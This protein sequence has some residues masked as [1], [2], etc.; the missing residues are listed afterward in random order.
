MTHGRFAMR[1]Y[2]ELFFRFLLLLLLAC[3]RGGSGGADLVQETVV[4]TDTTDLPIPAD[5]EEDREPAVDTAPDAPTVPLG[6]ANYLIVTAGNL[7]ETA[8]AFAEYRSQTGHKTAVATIKKLL[9][10]AAAATNT[11]MVTAITGWV[12]MYYE[13]RE[14]DLPFFLL[15]V[16]DAGATGNDPEITV[17]AAHWPGGWQGC[18]S[19]NAYGEMDGDDVPDLAVGRI[20]VRNNEDGLLILDKIIKHETEYEVG[21]WN[22]RI[23]V[24]A[25]EGGFGDDIDLAI[26]TIAQE[27][28]ESVPA[29]YDLK[30]AYNSP[31]SNYY[32]APFD[33]K[34]LDMLTEG[35]LLV[36]FM[37]HG[38]GE[39]NVPGSLADIVPKHRQPMYA[40]FA[41][42]TGDF[43]GQADCESETILK[44]EGGPIALLVSQATTHP[45]ANAIN[46]LEMEG[47]FF[48]DMPDTF[49]EAVQQMKWRSL[50]GD[51][52]IRQLIDA[53]APLYMSE[54]E[55]V[56]TIEDHMYSYNLLGDPATLIRFPH[57]T[58]EV[59]TEDGD[60]GGSIPF[61]GKVDSP[62]QGTAHVSIVCERAALIHKLT[63]VDKPAKEENWPTVQENWNKSNDHVVASADVEVIDGGFSGLLE[64]PK[65]TPGGTYFV[66]VY[67]ENGTLD[68]VGSAE[69]KIKKKT[70]QPLK[71][72]ETDWGLVTGDCGVIQEQLGLDTPSLFV[73]TYEFNDSESFDDTLLVEGA[74]DRYNSEN[75]GG[76]SICSEAMS[77]QLLHECEGADL[78]KME[79]EITYDV[80]GKMTDWIAAVDGQKVGVSV[81]RAYKGPGVSQYFE[82]DAIQLLEKKLSGILESTAN[83]SQEDA[84]VK[85]VLHVW[86]LQPDWVPTLQ[87]A[88]DQLSPDLKA[89]TIV[90]ITVEANSDYIV[91]N[92]CK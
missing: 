3:N 40:F 78:F 53:F 56:A 52:E 27:G 36:T 1:V 71:G 68:A 74:L 4:L 58:V 77:I 65:Q 22:H 55:M 80:E 67:A 81:T 87:A 6:E 23:H 82:E 61:S 57:G 63:P 25:G 31:G 11:A 51:S 13:A 42:S 60:S 43:I 38:G 64:I 85:Q 89:D 70:D 44:Q 91:T 69:I 66:T 26:E 30:F 62:A 50:Y 48:V 49:G 75:A 72:L 5:Q 10:N 92:T 29:E 33:Q 84:W 12:R 73:N 76:S 9:G 37:G 41:C 88:Y 47:A 90:L 18:Y 8:E 54:E 21:P 17:P 32:Y 45:Y 24:Y 2:R 15:I 28:L 35:A 20:P 79:T 59:D 14:P 83:V 39:T 46:A 7:L 16:G 86:T 19:D 34:V